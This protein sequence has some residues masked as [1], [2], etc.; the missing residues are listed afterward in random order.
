MRYLPGQSSVLADLLSRRDQVIGT[1]WCLYPRVARD[2]LRHWGSP[3]ID[4]FA[5]SLNAKLPL[6]CSPVPDPQAVFEDS[7]SSSLGQPGP[8]SI[9]T[10]S[11]GRKGGGSSQRD[12]QSL[13][14][15]DS[16]P[17]PP[18]PHLAR[19][20]V[21][22][23]PSPYPT[24]SGA[25]VVRPVVVAAPFQ[26][27]PQQRLCAE[28]SRVATLQHFLRKSGFLRGSTVEMSS[29]VC[30]S[31]SQLY[32]AK[33]MLFCGCCRGRGIAPVNATVPLIVNFL[34]HLFRDMGLSV[35]A[36]KGY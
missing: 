20:G 7:F 14:D 9:S 24:T 17:H 18:P 36:V 35:S 29:C 31:T 8:V 16:R 22:R 28:L 4:L 3:S 12:P 33:W 27:V 11:S 15:S 5:T 25:S 23:R 13:H 21:V 19:E 2:L 34:V 32:Q 1:E 6:Y 26:Q 10:L 30:T